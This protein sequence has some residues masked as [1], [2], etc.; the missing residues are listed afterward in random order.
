MLCHFE[1]KISKFHNQYSIKEI[2]K[3]N[4]IKIKNIVGSANVEIV[5]LEKLGYPFPAITGIY[6]SG[7]IYSSVHSA[8]RIKNNSEVSR[9]YVY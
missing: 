5:S 6:N 2:L 3:Q 1:S 4:N 8:G 9:N 7:N